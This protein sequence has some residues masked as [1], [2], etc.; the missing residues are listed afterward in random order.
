MPSVLQANQE[1]KELPET[2]EETPFKTKP[3]SQILARQFERGQ[4]ELLGSYQK[5]TTQGLQ[6]IHTEYRGLLCYEHV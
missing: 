4:K 6:R 5:G 1:D 3:G 2:P